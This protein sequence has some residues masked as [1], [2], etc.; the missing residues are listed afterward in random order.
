MTADT[1]HST[2]E[3]TT[4]PQ[5]QAKPSAEPP[6]WQQTVAAVVVEGGLSFGTSDWPLSDRK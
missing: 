3:S 6:G 1:R 5:N 2:E 4:N